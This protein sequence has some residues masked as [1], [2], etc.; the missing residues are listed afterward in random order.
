MEIETTG[1]AVK[2]SPT[3]SETHKNLTPYLVLGFGVMN[4][5]V[6]GAFS[7]VF[8]QYS[9]RGNETDLFYQIGLGLEVL[10]TQRISAMFDVNCVYGLNDLDEINYINNKIGI[11][12]HF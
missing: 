3:M 1:I 8:H 11:A 5:D 9:V 2:L 7:L 4:A 10:I 12:Y 6:G